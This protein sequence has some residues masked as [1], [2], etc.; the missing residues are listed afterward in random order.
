[1]SDVAGKTATK[2][3]RDARRRDG[4]D[5]C[6]PVRPSKSSRR[7][8]WVLAGV[9]AAILVHVAH[10]KVAGRTL[11][12][13][14]PSEAM[15]TL[16]L[17]YLNAGFLLFLVAAASTLIFGRFFCG[18]ACHVVAYQDLCGWAM[19]KVGVRPRPFRSRFLAYVP[20][21]AGFYMFFWPSL[22]RAVNF[23]EYVPDAVRRAF[24][25]PTAERWFDAYRRPELSNHLVVEDFWRTFPGPAV[26]ILTLVVCGPVIV[27]FLGNKGFCNYGC[28][29]GGLFGV[30]DRLAP[31]RIRVTDACE[32]CGHCTV[33]CTSD[34][35]VHEEVRVYG[36]VVDAKCLKCLDCVSVCPKDALYV[37][38]GAPAIATKTRAPRPKRTYDLTLGE[39]LALTAV[40][41]G[42]FFAW[43]SLYDAVPLLL[44]LGLASITAFVVRVL[45]RL[46]RRRPTSLQNLKLH[47]G[48]RLTVA[49]RVAAL[50]LG[51]F[52]GVV[53]H[54]GYVQWQG[55]VGG[56]RL[57]VHNDAIEAGRGDSAE[58]LAALRGA[59]E[60]F[61]RE[62]AAS[63]AR[64]PRAELAAGR[65]WFKLREADRAL[66]RLQGAVAFAPQAA[67]LRMMLAILRGTRGDAA[68]ALVEVEAYLALKP[69]DPDARKMQVELRRAVGR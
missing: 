38:W 26:A 65:S 20:F 25:W 45:W 58:S 23:A 8:A 29:Y 9:H 36:A 44:A 24:D 53:A 50:G 14:E 61:E 64:S 43:R 49:G 10:W 22:K 60:A 56:Y 32:G 66:P 15:Y 67:D 39:E 28:P 52:V 1:M 3:P 37:G 42:A 41:V 6:G 19:R 40:F 7:R 17:G 4:G 27:W 48:R 51:A 46:A 59:A 5:A 16:E 21:A 11:S 35:R 18:W 55:F 31:V 57:R 68:G 54:A 12:P 2:A 30:A 33:A 69:D 63:W 47:D 62:I 13:V 34:V